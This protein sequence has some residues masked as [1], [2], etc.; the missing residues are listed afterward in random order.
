MISL[1]RWIEG[2]TQID[3]VRFC[4][5]RWM[6]RWRK[7]ESKG[8]MKS[9]ISEVSASELALGLDSKDCWATFQRK[10]SAG[11]DSGKVSSCMAWCAEWTVNTLRSCTV[12]GSKSDVG[13]S[14]E[15]LEMIK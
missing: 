9:E 4:A 6:N 14:F 1:R 15:N 10:S 13:F 2:V 5:V 8:S 11:S 7:F 12:W 3:F